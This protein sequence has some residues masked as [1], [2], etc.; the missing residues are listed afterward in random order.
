MLFLGSRL[1]KKC[2]LFSPCY[3]GP[4]FFLYSLLRQYQY[5]IGVP[6]TGVGSAEG[7]YEL[8]N[9]NRAG[10]KELKRVI[11]VSRRP[12]ELLCKEGL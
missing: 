11:L 12:E 7:F 5:K 3:P 6:L 4:D 1:E 8:V 9:E 2:V 10:G